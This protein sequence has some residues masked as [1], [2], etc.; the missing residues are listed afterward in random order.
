MNK[1]YIVA[2]IVVVILV[3]GGWYFYSSMQ[4]SSYSQTQ[5]ASNFPVTQYPAPTSTAGSPASGSPSPSSTTAAGAAKSFTVHGNDL[6]ADLTT[7]TVS[8]GTSVSITF[9]VD[10]QNTYH[11]GLDFRSSML[12]TGTITPGSSKTVTF[13]ANSS[14]AFTPYWPLTNIKKPYTV[15][16][17]VQ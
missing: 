6:N 14:F 4:S 5:S 11:G 10:A 13:T 1:G 3:G 7:I 15:N 16:V 17:V 8:K 2:V 12:N 9:S